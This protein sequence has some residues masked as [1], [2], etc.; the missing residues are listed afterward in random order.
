MRLLGWAWM[1]GAVGV[2]LPVA[3]RAGSSTW[4]EMESPLIHSRVHGARKQVTKSSERVR[5]E[6]H[7]LMGHLSEGP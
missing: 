5:L 4:T 2:R 6:K 3:T 7:D 1:N